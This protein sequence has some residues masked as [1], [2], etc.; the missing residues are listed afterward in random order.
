M[1]RLPATAQ[2]KYVL[3]RFNTEWHKNFKA[4]SFDEFEESYRQWASSSKGGAAS[5]PAEEREELVD[6]AYWSWE[7]FALKKE[8]EQHNTLRLLKETGAAAA[9]ATKR[10]LGLTGTLRLW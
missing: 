4:M 7:M 6:E 10:F 9:D 5:H 2:Q 8:A 3:P 1:A